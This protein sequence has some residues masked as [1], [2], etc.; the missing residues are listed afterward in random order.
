VEL[1]QI[2]ML[3]PTLQQASVRKSNNRSSWIDIEPGSRQQSSVEDK[4]VGRE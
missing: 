3:N 1:V 2:K 4:A